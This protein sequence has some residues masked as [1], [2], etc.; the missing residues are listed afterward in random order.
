MTTIAVYPTYVQMHHSFC[1]TLSV[2]QDV[3]LA[4]ELFALS[5]SAQ[6]FTPI[7]NEH[8]VD[9]LLGGHD[10]LYYAGPGV[11]S[12]EGYDVSEPVLGTE[13][14]Q[15]QVL[16]IKSGSDFRDLSSFDLVLKHTSDDAVRKVVISEIHGLFFSSSFFFTAILPGNRQAKCGPP[17]YSFFS[18][19]EASCGQNPFVRRIHSQGPCL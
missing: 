4:R 10:H 18:R 6:S 3:L 11:T 17:H 8:G 13:N 9:L 15:G 14:D 2:F 7:H 12:W 19:D 16:V 1:D 5:P